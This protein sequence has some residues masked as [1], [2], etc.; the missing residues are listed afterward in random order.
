MFCIQRIAEQRILKAIEEGAFDNLSGKGKPL[1]LEDDSRIPE[2]LR[3]A[4]KILKNAGYLPPEISLR[5]EIAKIEDLLAGMKDTKA[6]Y[7]QLKK[8]NFLIM[9]LNALR[10][11]PTSLEKVQHYEKKL[12][13]HFGS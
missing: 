13:E 4:Y 3:M 8:L 10:P 7:R 9:K 12:T 6:K 11:V 5:K 2:D 1:T